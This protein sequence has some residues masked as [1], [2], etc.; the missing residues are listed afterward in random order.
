MTN[1]KNGV[2]YVLTNPSFPEY[3]KIGYADNLE[4]RL[5]ELNRSECLPFAFRAYCVYE[6]KERL[7]DKDVHAL[8]DRINSEL[9]AIETFDGKPRVREF[10]NISAEDAY[11]ILYSIAAISSTTNRLKRITPE[12]HEVLDEQVAQDIQ[13]NGKV[14]YTEEDHLLHSSATTKRLYLEIRDKLLSLG[15]IVIE[16]KKLYIAF[17][18]KSNICD[19]EIQRNKL[20]ITVNIRHGKID[21]P[22]GI[23]RDISGIGHWGNG[24]YEIHLADDSMLQQALEIIMQS[25]RM[26]NNLHQRS[27]QTPRQS[28]L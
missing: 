4:K 14:E 27:A 23:A 26:S 28:R 18:R 6:T 5:S 7:K 1:D 10:Y 21:D 8:I 25:Y 19:I 20:K 22:A 9:R 13:E 16:P 15:D 17:K 12:G 11:E 2:I 3:V 24:D